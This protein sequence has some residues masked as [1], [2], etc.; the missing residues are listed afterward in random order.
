MISVTDIAVQPILPLIAVVLTAIVVLLVGSFGD[1]EQESHYGYIGIAGLMLAAFFNI[2]LWNH[3]PF[4]GYGGMV[5]V[6]KLAVFS[7]MIFLFAAAVTFLSSPGYLSVEK[8]NTGEYYGLI[9]FAVAG[10][11][12][13]VATNHLVMFFLGLEIL[14]ISLY[15]LSG[16]VRQRPVCNEAAMKYLF[17]GAFATGFLLLGMALIYAEVSTLSLSGLVEYLK[18]AKAPG[19]LFVVGILLLFVGFFF[20]ISAVPFHFWAPDVYGGAPAPVTGFMATAAK[21]AAFVIIL[22]VC[23]ETIF[24]LKGLWIPIV[25]I[26]AVLSMVVGNFTALRQENI[27]RMLAYSSIA[28]AGYVLVGVAAATRQGASS[29]LFY[30]AAYTVMNVGA[31]TVVAMLGRKD[32]SFVNI[33]DY[34]GLAAK[35]PVLAAAMAIF[36]FSLAGVPGTAGF[37]GKFYVFAAGLKAGQVPLVIIALINSA[38]AAYYYLRVVVMMYTKEPVEEFEK[39]T[40][41]PGMVAAVAIT[42]LAVFQLGI[43]PHM[44]MTSSMLSVLPWGIP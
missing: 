14:S 15:A 1:P 38:V 34:A 23:M 11:I 10:M 8:R 37:M 28:H 26:L 36:M 20:K 24:P 32:E 17:L 27:K 3:P 35:R 6:D 19:V 5:L 16:F 22:R 30:M 33:S 25:S 31:F 40:V 2:K 39:V 18:V 43:V 13:M 4:V 21:A 7:T 12:C 44:V 29:V 41:A 42:V 9:L